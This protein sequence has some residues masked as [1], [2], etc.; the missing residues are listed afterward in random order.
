MKRNAFTFAFL[1][2]ALLSTSGTAFAV[3]PRSDGASGSCRRA[4]RANPAPPVPPPSKRSRRRNSSQSPACNPAGAPGPVEAVASAPL[5][6]PDPSTVAAAFRRAGAAG[7]GLQVPGGA[8]ADMNH[9]YF[10]EMHPKYG[11]ARPFFAQTAIVFHQRLPPMT[12]G[13]NLF[14]LDWYVYSTSADI[15]AICLEENAAAIRGILDSPYFTP[16]ENSR[17][18]CPSGCSVPTYPRVL[19][20]VMS[21]LN[22]KHDN[23][24]KHVCELRAHQRSEVYTPSQLNQF[25][26]DHL[27]YHFSTF[28][29]NEFVQDMLCKCFTVNIYKRSRK[30][31][32]KLIC[33]S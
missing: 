5:P 31:K 10:R 21:A 33:Y 22:K 3:P 2:A 4:M 15:F 24:V 32:L 17:V 19:L 1:L 14:E 13:Q 6:A 25:F 8:Y 16:Q 29:K 12:S 26:R 9:Y 7:A 18:P 20:G 23:L 28:E 11:T 27:T 30:A